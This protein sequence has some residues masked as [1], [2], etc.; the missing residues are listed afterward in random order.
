MFHN[1]RRTAV[2]ICLVRPLWGD[3]STQH[4][5]ILSL[6]SQG[7]LP[8]SK[9]GQQQWHDLFLVWKSDSS[10]PSRK[11]WVVLCDGYMAHSQCMTSQT[12]TGGWIFSHRLGRSE[13]FLETIDTNRSSRFWRKLS[14]PWV[15]HNSRC[16]F[17]LTLAD[18]VNKYS[19]HPGVP[20]AKWQSLSSNN[21]G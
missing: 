15:L 6:N 20:P 12:P 2:Q 18:T 16:P 5:L 17:S 10:V 1:D 7:E 19:P 9:D 11:D 13:T 3:L 14:P 21:F 4:F 8:I